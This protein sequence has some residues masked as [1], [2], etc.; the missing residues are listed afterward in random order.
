MTAYIKKYET[1]ARSSSTR[2]IPASLRAPA[3]PSSLGTCI[4]GWM[5]ASGQVAE[6]W[7]CPC[8]QGE[9]LSCHHRTPLD[10]SSALASPAGVWKRKEKTRSVVFPDLFSALPLASICFSSWQKCPGCLSCTDLS[11]RAAKASELHQLSAQAENTGRQ[12]AEV[13]R[14]LILF[15]NMLR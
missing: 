6:R 15:Y 10:G 4:C 8:Y 11:R 2:H 9:L 13:C 12:R 1:S 3:S 7:G 14:G 5:A